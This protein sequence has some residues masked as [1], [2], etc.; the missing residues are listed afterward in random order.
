L[1]GLSP[2]IQAIFLQFTAALLF[3]L[4]PQISERRPNSSNTLP[5]NGIHYK[6]WQLYSGATIGDD[7]GE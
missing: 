5:E 4:C 7:F 6:L 3:G 1:A 2:W